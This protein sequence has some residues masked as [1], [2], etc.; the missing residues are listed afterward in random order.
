[1]GLFCGNSKG[2][3]A[4][5][6]FHRRAAS[7][8]FDGI[9][10]ATLSEEKVSTTGVTQRNLKIPLPPNYLDSHQTQ[11]NKIKSWIE[12]T[13]RFHS[14][15]GELIHWIGKAKNRSLTVGQL[16]IIAGW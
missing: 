10:N 3:K 14:F 7:L 5:G 9:L 16:P 6:Y 15:E 8:M 2:V 12:L 1:M 4:I 13:P 11:N